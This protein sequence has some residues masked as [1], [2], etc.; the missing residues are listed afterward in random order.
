MRGL[1]MP[2]GGIPSN[3][4]LDRSGNPLYNCFID[5]GLEKIQPDFAVIAK[6]WSWICQVVLVT[7]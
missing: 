2:E 6:K 3:H 1:S 7:Y 4:I 5:K